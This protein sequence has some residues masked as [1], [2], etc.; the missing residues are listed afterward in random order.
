MSEK[1]LIHEYMQGKI[2]R[3]E[4][5]KLAGMLGMSL[6]AIGGALAAC[7]TPPEAHRR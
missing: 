4:F 3:R 2:N 1:E 7:G 5:V 6:T